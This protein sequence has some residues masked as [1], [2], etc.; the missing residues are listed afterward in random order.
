MKKFLLK[1]YKLI[2][3][4]LPNK[5]IFHIWDIYLSR[6]TIKSFSQYGEDLVIKNF[7]DTQGISEGYYIDIGCYHP[8]GISNTHFLHQKGWEGLV[9]DIDDYKLE[10]FKKRRGSQVTTLKAAI[11]SESLES[12]VQVYKF[13]QP[14]SPYDT[15]SEEVAKNRSRKIGIPFTTDLVNQIDINL[16]LKERH[17]DLLNIDVEGLDELIVSSVNFKKYQPTLIIYESWSPLEPSN[18]KNI[19]E[20]NGYSLLFISGGSIGYYK[21][22]E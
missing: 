13:N 10:L 14:F 4:F 1:I 2:K 18:T 21:K 5:I 20:K 8:K 19:L 16:I 9:I 15:L 12:P 3:K 11:S 17:C 6:L 7:F 22:S